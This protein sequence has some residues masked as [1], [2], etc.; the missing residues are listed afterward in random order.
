MSKIKNI[1][2]NFEVIAGQVEAQQMLIE[3]IIV[4]AIRTKA[5]NEAEILTVLTQGM[6]AFQNNPN[7]GNHEKFGAVGTFTSALDI[8]ER[9]K[10][11]GIIP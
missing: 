1:E 5:I 9:S 8:I 10:D 11:A 6:D 2:R 3:S 4:E 7:L